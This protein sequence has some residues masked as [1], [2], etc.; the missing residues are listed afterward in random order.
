MQIFLVHTIVVVLCT[1]HIVSKHFVLFVAVQF[2]SHH[3]MKLIRYLV[4][5]TAAYGAESVGVIRGPILTYRTGSFSHTRSQDFLWDCTF[6]P[7]KS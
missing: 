3:R 1:E 5:L 6:L 7:P 4:T 2:L